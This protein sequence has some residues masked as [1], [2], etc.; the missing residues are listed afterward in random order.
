MPSKQSSC[1]IQRAS[2]GKK[3]VAIVFRTNFTVSAYI[4]KQKF[5]VSTV[6]LCR[7]GPKFTKNCFNKSLN[8][9]VDFCSYFSVRKRGMLLADIFILENNLYFYSDYKPS[10]DVFSGW[11]YLRRKKELCIYSAFRKL[12]LESFG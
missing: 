8:P 7:C 3:T 2:S 5:T 4:G 6:I 10:Y 9:P 12:L 1:L 11:Q